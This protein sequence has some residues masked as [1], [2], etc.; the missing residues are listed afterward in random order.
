MNEDSGSI[1]ISESPGPGLGTSSGGGEMSAA[2]TR[3]HRSAVSGGTSAP[4]S[5]ATIN[6]SLATVNEQLAGSG[7]TRVLRTDPVSGVTIVEVRNAS[8]GQVLQRIPSRDQQHLADMV[9]A[10]ANGKSILADVIA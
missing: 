4:A 6:R 2:P 1:S 8:T 9:A 3:T 10:G 5:P 7:H